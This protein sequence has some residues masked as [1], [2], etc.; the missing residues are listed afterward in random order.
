MNRFSKVPPEVLYDQ[1]LTVEHLRVY[2]AL[3]SSVRGGRNTTNIG[4][5]LISKLTKL[6]K[7]TVGRR[8]KELAEFGHVVSEVDHKGMRAHFRMISPVFAVYDRKSY[9]RKGVNVG[10]M[11]STVRVASAWAKTSVDRSEI[12]A[13]LGRKESA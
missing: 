11:S 9:G 6:S 12:D 4:Q 7:T 2:G 13:I 10:G 1:N 5:R 3:A 8:L